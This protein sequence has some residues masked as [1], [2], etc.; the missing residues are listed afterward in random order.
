MRRWALGLPEQLAYEAPGLDGLRVPD[1]PPVRVL[2]AG[3]GGSGVSGRFLEALSHERDVPVIPWPWSGAPRWLSKKDALLAVSH[4][5]DTRE[6]LTTLREGV[7]SGA[8]VVGIAT[9][10]RLGEFMEARG[11]PL[12]V[13]PAGPPPRAAFGHL[14]G[15]VLRVVERLTGKKFWEPA[16]TVGYLGRLRHRLA[17]G[18][19]ASID[20]L[21][22]S[23]KDRPVVVYGTCPLTAAAAL[24]LK[25]QLNENAKVHAW[26]DTLPELAHNELE[27]AGPGEP[28]RRLCLTLADEPPL[29]EVLDDGERTVYLKGDGPDPLTAALGLVLRGDLLSLALARQRGVDPSLIER[30]ERFKGMG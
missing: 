1:R 14:L 18:D 6:T 30:I 21:A 15:T 29:D 8:T 9:G 12:L 20:A 4:S 13:V 3:M 26:A 7:E 27:G 16:E 25:Q 2:V 19:Y 28:P 17:G 5:G 23:I 10:G 22:G 11:L 24:R